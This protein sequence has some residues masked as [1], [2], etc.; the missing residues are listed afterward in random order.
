[1]Q[2]W[3]V[4]SRFIDAAYGAEAPFKGLTRWRWQFVENPWRST[5][6]DLVPVWIA[7]DG[8]HVVG[9]TAVQ[10]G[11]LH[12]QSEPHAAGWIVDVMVLPSHR[13]LGLGHQVHDPIAAA[14]P[15]LVTLTMA[16]ATRRIAEKAGCVTLGPVEQ[17]GRPVRPNARDIRRYLLHRTGHHPRLFRATKS[18]CAV[19]GHAVIAALLAPLLAIRDL[20]GRPSKA[21]GIT[22]TQPAD[23]IAKIDE[24]W[25]RCSGQY[26]AIF[27]RSG[28]FA[29]WRFQRAP[30]LQYSIF[31]AERDGRPVG[32]SVLRR[33]A[34]PE[35]RNGVITDLFTDRDVPDALP[36]LIDH[37][38]MYFGKGVAGIEAG[39]S[40]P[41]V[42]KA[43]RNRGFLKI[44][45]HYPTVVCKDQRTRQA[46]ES[47]RDQFYFT[48]ADHDWDQVYPA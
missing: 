46:I 44:R 6:G 33:R 13:G 42:R 8:P 26:A 16:A 4:I 40:L 47:L 15:L 1:V 21:A 30:N 20:L 45:T 27:E 23:P 12:L 25:R 11:M 32:Y 34:D 5:R 39:A 38:L 14:M 48:K 28:A 41:D 18:L 43:L 17:L 31:I 29:A 2:D 22:I 9:Q 7:L 24:L 37:A 36:A 19:G 3:E 35:L 10:E